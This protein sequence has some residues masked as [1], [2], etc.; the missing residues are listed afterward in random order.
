MSVDPEERKPV[1]SRVQKDWDTEE[2]LTVGYTKVFA[3]A[4]EDYE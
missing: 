3:P 2:R 4:L 1:L